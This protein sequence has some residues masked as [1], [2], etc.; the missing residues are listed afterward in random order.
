MTHD[1][2]QTRPRPVFWGVLIALTLL[3]CDSLIGTYLMF[4]RPKEISIQRGLPSLR[5]VA[6]PYKSYINR[7][8]ERYW[9]KAEQ[10]VFSLG[11][12]SYDFGVLEGGTVVNA[13]GHQ[14]RPMDSALLSGKKGETQ[15]RIL[16]LGGSTTFQPWPHLVGEF[17]DRMQP[18]RRHIVIN[19]GTGGYT[20]QENAIDLL[21]AGLS[22]QPDMVVAYLPVN[23][24]YWAAGYPGFKRDYTH[25][26]IP[27]EV[28]AGQK[29][30]PILDMPAY[31][32]TAKL[33]AWKSYKRE[34]TEWARRADIT[35]LTNKQ[36]VPTTLWQSIDE[37]D[38]LATVDAVIDNIISMKA[39][40]D[41][42]GIKFILVTQKLF[43][44]AIGKPPLPD[45]YVLRAVDEIETS[46]LLAGVPKISLG[47][48]IPDK[49]D[50]RWV[51]E[52]RTA[53]PQAKLNFD[54]GMAYDTMHFSP[55]GL[56]LVA[57][58]VAR[59]VSSLIAN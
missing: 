55:A 6:H 41:A 35:Y 12:K 49:W 46:R 11:D 16:F 4:D 31:P 24:I 8:D 17:L 23:D 48:K 34:M 52:V 26:R 9:A 7:P 10:P 20:S 21:T 37:K 51:D 45:T 54:Q 25:L 58:M 32:F 39:V 18:H 38:Y 57:M 15:Y 14:V 50:S 5:V 22:Y 43:S 3:A 40:C 1:S 56:H 33:I 2:T 36:P 27:L 44:P 19:A 30:I 29:S 42:R 47:K 59:N 28:A 53:F 13:F